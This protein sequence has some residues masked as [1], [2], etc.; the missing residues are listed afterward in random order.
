MNAGKLDKKI[1]F[2]DY[3]LVKKD[4]MSQEVWE[5]FKTVYAMVRTI[6][7]REFYQAASVQNEYT[8][9]FIIRYSAGKNI[10]EN[11][12]IVYRNRTFEIVSII[13]DNEKDE[14]LTIMV[15]ELKNNAD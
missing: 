10:N 6:S 11:M 13:N 3:K 12:R 8:T 14:T 9:R 7:G 1:T 4:G 2:Q 15:K 5:D